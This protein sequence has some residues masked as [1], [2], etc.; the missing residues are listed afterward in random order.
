MTNL[1]SE[2]C[3]VIEREKRWNYSDFKCYTAFA[4]NYFLSNKYKRVMIVLPQGF[5]AYALIWGAYLAK[6]TF[7]P[8]NEKNPPERKAYFA[9]AFKPDII[10]SDSPLEVAENMFKVVSSTNFFEGVDEFDMLNIQND[11]TSSNLAYVIFTSGS[12]GLPKG[13]M[14]NWEALDSFVEYCVATWE[15]T[16]EDVFGQYSNLGFD[17]SIADI[18]VSIICGATLVPIVSDSEKLMPGKMIK[19]HK[20]TFWHSVPSVVDLLDRAKDLN[21]STLS[22]LRTISFCGEKLFQSH[23]DKLF[24]SKKDLIVFNT[25]GPTET[26]I[27][28]SLQKITISNYKLFAD[29]TMAIGNAINGMVLDICDVD[30]NGVGELYISGINVSLGYLNDV[31]LT[32]T[33]FSEEII[34]GN[35][36][37][38]YK[39]GDF[40]YKKDENIYFYGRKDSQIKKMGHRVDLSEVDYWLREYGCSAV[41]TVVIDTKIVS[42]VESEEYQADS[43]LN[44]LKTKLPE[45]Y[46]PQRIVTLD[47]LPFNLSGKIDN[48]KMKEEIIEI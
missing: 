25:Y 21:E 24:Q 29:K 31:S 48:M 13:V 14:I 16:K 3:A 44:Y 19:K 47:K 38:K 36:V 15:V 30:E 8:V 37:R 10:I 26:T 41:S 7:C 20:I 11:T 18:F 39:T 32:N 35:V 34:D 33:V 5:D 22:S 9:Q 27:F 1:N 46:L 23:L 43:I 28:C 42:F 12:T 6:I 4:M 45:Y 40:M 2:K 17:L